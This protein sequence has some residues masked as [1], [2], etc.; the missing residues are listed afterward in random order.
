[1][2]ST[3]P[4]PSIFSAAPHAPQR[5]SE[6]QG[7]CSGASPAASLRTRRPGEEYRELFLAQGIKR[8]ALFFT[9]LVLRLSRREAEAHPAARR[10]RGPFRA[11]P[12][13]LFPGPAC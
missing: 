10:D 5:T 8:E 3:G 6:A 13:A 4:P 9:R 1:M 7:R 2:R 12:P 11:P